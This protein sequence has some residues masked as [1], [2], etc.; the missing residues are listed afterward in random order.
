MDKAEA[1]HLLSHF[2]ERTDEVPVDDLVAALEWAAK[3]RELNEWLAV[4]RRDDDVFS[5]AIQAVA[6][7]TGLREEILAV[8]DPEK[9]FA[10]ESDDFDRAMSDRLQAVEPPDNLR[11][12]I[13]NAMQQSAPV[14]A[15]PARRWWKFAAPLA[16]AAGVAVAFLITLDD[17]AG[18][19][20]SPLTDAGISRAQPGAVVPVSRVID[21]TISHLSQPSFQF[22][23]ASSELPELITFI[24]ENGIPCPDSVIPD[25]LQQQVALGCS[26]V[27]IDQKHGAVI[28]FK[29]SEQQ[30]AHLVI[31]SSRDVALEKMAVTGQRRIQRGAWN[32]WPWSDDQRVLVLLTDGPPEVL[33]ELF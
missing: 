5:R 24:G 12:E 21:A 3:D 7:P 22:A 15:R 31:M 13:L 6:L 29:L 17:R 33:E 8:L 28:C 4:E 25:G 10:L 19:P 32:A 18:S 1:R 23:R 11:V 14:F 2:H 26:F 20:V 27:R 30:F 9:S 16:A